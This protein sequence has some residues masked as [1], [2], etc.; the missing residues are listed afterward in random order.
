MLDVVRHKMISFPMLLYEGCKCTISL[1]HF[2]GTGGLLSVQG[3]FQFRVWE[4]LW[5]KKCK[6][7]KKERKAKKLTSSQIPWWL[8]ETVTILTTVLAR[9]AQELP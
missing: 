7:N 5:K 2:G 3:C 9:A 6:W 8:L 1:S 4:M